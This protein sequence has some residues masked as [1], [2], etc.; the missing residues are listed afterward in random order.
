M[1]IVLAVAKPGNRLRDCPIASIKGREF[2]QNAQLTF[3]TT[4][5]GYPNQKGTPPIVG[6][7]QHLI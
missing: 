2:C 6:C 7:G 3:S 5:L 4:S 1:K